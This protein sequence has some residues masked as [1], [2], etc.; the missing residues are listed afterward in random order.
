MNAIRRSSHLLAA[1][2]GG[3]EELKHFPSPEAR[4]KALEEME[5][6]IRGWDLM[7]GI[8]ITATAGI[9]NFFAGKY[10]AAWLIPNSFPQLLRDLPPLAFSAAVVFVTLRL[11]HRWGAAPELRDRLIDAGV[12]VCRG[13]GYLLRGLGASAPSCPECG[14]K[15]DDRVRTLI[16][17]TAPPDQGPQ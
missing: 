14:R 1:T 16:D 5:A 2:L 8:V 3:L 12:P 9:G 4:R 17:A 10:A 6:G 13:C 7:L 15:I 11:L